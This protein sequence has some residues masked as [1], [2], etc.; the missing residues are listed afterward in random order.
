MMHDA[1]MVGK[2]ECPLWD[3]AAK[4]RSWPDPTT[5]QK[6]AIHQAHVAKRCTPVVG[7]QDAGFWGSTRRGRAAP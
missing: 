2:R 1:G 6:I 4:D 7:G 5:F 3:R